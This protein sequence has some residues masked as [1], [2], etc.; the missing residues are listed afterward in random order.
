VAVNRRTRHGAK[1]G[2]VLDRRRP[3][4]TP[5]TGRLKPPDPRRAQAFPQPDGEPTAET[6]PPG[7]PSNRPTSGNSI[8]AKRRQSGRLRGQQ[9]VAGSGTCRTTRLQV[10]SRTRPADASRRTPR[11][12]PLT[13]RYRWQPGGGISAR[14]AWPG[15]HSRAK[16]WGAH[17]VEVSGNR[18]NQG[19]GQTAYGIRR[20]LSA[21]PHTLAWNSNFAR[22]VRQARSL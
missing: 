6:A 10:T 18:E 3:L 7:T 21:L 11:T 2:I 1:A 13:Q 15:T 14:T 5:S 9:L 12:L 20:A 8:S 22:N 16:A 17:R 19:S 4:V